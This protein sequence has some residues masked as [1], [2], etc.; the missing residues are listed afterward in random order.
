MKTDEINLLIEK[1]K[2]RKD[3]VYSFR[4]YFWA[5][6]N[7]QFIAFV[8]PKGEV[9][10]RFGGFNIQIGDLRSLEYTWERKAKFKKWLKSL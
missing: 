9:L 2:T 1:A 7:N 4:G 5:V 6:K 8:T 3:G 10:E